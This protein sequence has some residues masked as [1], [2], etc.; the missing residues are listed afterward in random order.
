MRHPFERD[1]SPALSAPEPK[2][3]AQVGGF[4][5]LQVAKRRIGQDKARCLWDV[6]L[7]EAAVGRGSALRLNGLINR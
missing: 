6:H 1:H 4:L 3:Q 2:R 7:L 5:P